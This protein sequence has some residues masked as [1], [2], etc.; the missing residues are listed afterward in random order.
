MS[1]VPCPVCGKAQATVCSDEVDI[2]VGTLTRVWGYSCPTCG[3]IPV[4]QHCGGVADEHATW[5]EDLRQEYY[6]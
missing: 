4:C 3:L 6:P 2:G 5:C 1:E